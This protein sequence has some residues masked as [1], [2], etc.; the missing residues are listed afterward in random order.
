M[1]YDRLEPLIERAATT[2]E[3]AELVQ[4]EITSFDAGFPIRL[5]F[6]DGVDGTE[7]DLEWATE[8][9]IMFAHY[10]PDGDFLA[11]LQ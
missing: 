9:V 8:P 1:N 10:A 2:A 5:I 3:L 4:A 6:M 11:T 7:T